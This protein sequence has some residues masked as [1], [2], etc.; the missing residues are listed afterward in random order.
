MKIKRADVILIIAVLSVAALSLLLLLL[1]SDNGERVAVIQGGERIGVYDLHTD[2]SLLIN[3]PD[4]SEKANTLVISDGKAYIK[5]A[6]CPDKYCE[7]HRP[8]FLNGQTIVCLP[9]DLMIMIE[10]G[11]NGS[12]DVIQ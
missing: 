8:I 7:N 6:S 11:A 2:M 4:D 5:D 1:F 12:P 3:S 9:H 10:G